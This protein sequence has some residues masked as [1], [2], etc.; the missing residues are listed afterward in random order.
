MSTEWR[1]WE[2]T[3]ATQVQRTPPPSPTLSL[4]SLSSHLLLAGAPV[5]VRREVESPPNTAVGRPHEVGAGRLGRAG[6]RLDGAR[7]LHLQRVAH[8]GVARGAAVDPL[9]SRA[10]GVREADGGTGHGGQR[11]GERDG[12]IGGGEEGEKEGAGEGHC[13]TDGADGDGG[14]GDAETEP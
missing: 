12:G 1:R 3:A 14:D 11:R 7:A 6:D 8:V 4:T 5:P 10:R 9:G 2:G 13:E